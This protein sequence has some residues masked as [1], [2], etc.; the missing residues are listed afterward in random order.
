LFPAIPHYNL[1]KAHT[2]LKSTNEEYRDF[3][4]ECHGTFGNPS[5]HPTILDVMEKPTR[6]PDASPLVSPQESEVQLLAS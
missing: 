3:V 5:G 2:L 6:E 4:V 1:A